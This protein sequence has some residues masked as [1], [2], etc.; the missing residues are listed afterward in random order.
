MRRDDVRGGRARE[1]AQDVAG[2]NDEDVEERDLLETERIEDG[3]GRVDER[4]RE[5]RRD[6]QGDDE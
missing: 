6:R 3:E 1:D 4:P 2:R 5:R